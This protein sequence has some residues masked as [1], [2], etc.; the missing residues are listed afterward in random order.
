LYHITEIEDSAFA[1]SFY[2]PNRNLSGSVTISNFV[3][4]IRSSAFRSCELLSTLI[5]CDGVESIGDDAFNGCNG[6][7]GNLVIPGSVTSIGDHAFYHDSSFNAVVICEGV[8][9]MGN[10]VFENCF[11]LERITI[12]NSIMSIGYY[13]FAGC[14]LSSITLN[15]FTSTD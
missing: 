2:Y 15:G 9:T 13:A 7:S 6:L 12:S 8:K 4:S 3:V 10:G 11:N 5:I 14:P 1:N